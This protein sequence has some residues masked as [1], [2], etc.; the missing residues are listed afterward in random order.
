MASHD[1]AAPVPSIEAA[2]DWFR[3]QFDAE[4]SRGLRAVYEIELTGES[5]GTLA[6]RVEDGRLDVAPGPA[7]ASDL[8]LSLAIGDFFAILAGR[9]NA[10]ML[11]MED[12]IG[13]S[14]DLSL[15]LKMRRLFR[16]QPEEPSAT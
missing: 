8:R 6:L 5:G 14:G 4:A 3:K 12:R 11:F 10:D 9:A 2:G 15:A 16:G 1:R 13:W 7:G